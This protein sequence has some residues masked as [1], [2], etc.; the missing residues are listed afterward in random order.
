[1]DRALPGTT[2]SCPS[3]QES[4]AFSVLEPIFAVS[5]GGLLLSQ[6]TEMTGLAPSTIQNWVKRGWV[7]NPVNKKYDEIRV[8]RILLINLLR[9]SMQLER[10]AHLLAYVNGSVYDREDDSI[11]DTR[12]YSLVCAAIFRLQDGGHM[13]RET[14][15][16]L[17]EAQLRDYPQTVP[18]APERLLNALEIILLSVEAASCM[19]RAEERYEQS[20]LKE[21][22]V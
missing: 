18:D 6:V 17:I 2:L 4:N 3:T 16:P 20:V 19:K 21:A 13:E 9:N 5:G 10:I 14:L 1:M 15:V 8:A 7:A 11:S 12:L 22:S